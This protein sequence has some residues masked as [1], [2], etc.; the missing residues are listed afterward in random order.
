MQLL[1]ASYTNIISRAFGKFATAEFP[2]P[3][4]NFIN[5]SYVKLL[6]LDMSEFSPP[7]NYKTLNKLFTRAF[8]K[9][10]EIDGASDSVI[11]PTDS[12]ITTS[13]KI[14]EDLSLQL[15]GFWYSVDD[16][17]TQFIDDKSKKKIYGGEYINFYLSPTDYHRYHMPLDCKIKK[18]IH[19]P[20]ALY[21][22]NF[23]YLKKMPEL[24]VKNERVIVECEANKKL[25]Y[26]ILVGALNVGKMTI[27]FEP[28]I[29]TNTDSK[30]IKVY[31]YD[32]M[33]L[34]KGF[35]LGYFLMGSTV[36]ILFEKNMI[37]LSCE[38]DKKIRFGDLVATMK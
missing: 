8:V 19:V 12:F 23:T 20:G 10:R 6:K 31:E 9:T 25:F 16:L 28:D 5:R 32:D 14:K 33:N 35:E 3:I 29:E 26:M 1:K 34:S 38:N 37:E 22:V 24:Y 4:Q 13:G 2:T 21:P 15:K 7:H 27:S 36:V 30:E 17:L 11:S 18:V